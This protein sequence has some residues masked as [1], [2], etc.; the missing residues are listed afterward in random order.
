ME[1]E[2]K[3]IGY[4]YKEVAVNR[5]ME[6][7]WA[8]CYGS[9]GWILEG[10]SSPLPGKNTVNLKFKRDRKIRNKMEL[11]RLQRQFEGSVKQIENL[12]NS[13][14]T[15]ALIF[16]IGVGI[17]GTAFMALAVFSYLKGRIFLH[18]VFAIP[19]F[20]GWILPYFGYRKIV[21]KKADKINPIIEEVYDKIYDTCEKASRLTEK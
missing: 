18:I 15:A 10:K 4:E 3:F 13:K 9:F 21:S 11:T 12:E 5:D 1:K 17:L 16:A 14:Y 7:L 20:L 8:D 2:Y 6:S 19:A